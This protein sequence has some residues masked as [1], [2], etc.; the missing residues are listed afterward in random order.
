M[1]DL[2]FILMLIRE[3]LKLWASESADPLILIIFPGNASISMCCFY[4]CFFYLKHNP[5]QSSLDL[6]HLRDRVSPGLN[7]KLST[8]PKILLH[9]TGSWTPEAED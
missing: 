7:L 2:Y 6:R 5:P 1:N 8:K 4:V 3:R 9:S